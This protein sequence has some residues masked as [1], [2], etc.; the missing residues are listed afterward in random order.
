VKHSQSAIAVSSRTEQQKTSTPR[1]DRRYSLDG[2]AKEEI[3]SKLVA[4]MALMGFRKNPRVMM[5]GILSLVA[6]G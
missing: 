2:P 4:K 1:L 6:T 3:Q 5:A